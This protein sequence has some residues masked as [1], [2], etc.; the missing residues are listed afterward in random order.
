MRRREATLVAGRRRFGVA[1]DGCARWNV[2]LRVEVLPVG[3]GLGDE[4][5]TATAR[6]R[7]SELGLGFIQVVVVCVYL[8]HPRCVILRIIMTGTRCVVVVYAS[9]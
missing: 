9:A 3:V 1:V 6:T 2:A 5:G 7:I 4:S 8:R